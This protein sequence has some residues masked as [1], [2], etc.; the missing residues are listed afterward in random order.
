MLFHTGG[1]PEYNI[2]EVYKMRI[3]VYYETLDG[4]KK[5]SSSEMKNAIGKNTYFDYY[6][7]FKRCDDRIKEDFIIVV[8]NDNNE[9]IHKE[10]VHIQWVTNPSDTKWQYGITICG[11]RVV[12]EVR[13]G[14]K[15]LPICHHNNRKWYFIDVQAFDEK[16]NPLFDKKGNPV[17]QKQYCA[18]S[19]KIKEVSSEEFPKGVLQQLSKINYS[20]S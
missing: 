10:F 17:T 1:I 8:Y 3:K 4:E 12:S 13:Y 14:K 7:T 2:K 20:I 19:S 11:N 6:Q 18:C 5:C 16:G 9:I 15:T